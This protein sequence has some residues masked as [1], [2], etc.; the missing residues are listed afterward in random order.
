MGKKA[1]K[2]DKEPKKG[3]AAFECKNCGR[4]ARKK[5]QVC[6]PKKRR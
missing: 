2:S 3:K 4:T 1:C 5:D 6:K